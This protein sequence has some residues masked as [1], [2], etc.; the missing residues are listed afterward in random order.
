MP[1]SWIYDAFISYSHRDMNWGRWLQR[2]LET[3]KIPKD[4]VSEEQ[5]AKNFRV[6]RDQTDL[7]GVELQTA[8]RK[9]LETS[10]FLIV[11][12]SPNSAASSW[13]NDEVVAFHEMGRMDHV[14]PFI[15]EGEPESEDPSLECY[16]PGLRS[17][18]GRHMLGANIQE[19]GKE[20]AF[21]KLVSIMLDVRFN[22]LVDRE[23]QRR[24]RMTLTIGSISAV[25][26]AIV[27][28]LLI[29]NAMISKR[30]HELSYDAYNSALSAAFQYGSE[31]EDEL[32][33]VDI[34]PLIASSEE[35]NT[36]AI[37][38]L[39]SCYRNGWGTAVDEDAAFSWCKKGAE[40]GDPECMIA[41]GHCY[42]YGNGTQVNGEEALN[43]YLKAAETDDPGGMV[44]AGV[45]YEDGVGTEADPEQAFYWYKKAADTGYTG[46]VEQLAR[47]YL[48]GI[49]CEQ[50]PEEAFK[51]DMQLAELGNADAM[52]NAGLMYQYGFGTEEDPEK[53]YYWYRKGAEAGDAL[54][55]YRVAQ[56]T[57]TNYGTKNAAAEWYKRAVE[58]AEESGDTDVSEAAKEEIE[59]L[60]AAQ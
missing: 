41:L 40:L 30:N 33:D 35:G 47:C 39:V 56:C 42:R 1:G 20:K 60:N 7:A 50:N 21:L 49:G 55:A 53:A 32:A 37:M 2:R 16:P 4:M 43:W 54:S 36:D 58:L 25:T 46:G 31:L 38:L 28:G 57:E 24:R 13:V 27:I 22:R 52:Y 29:H 12:C 17:S 48:K 26:A 45:A 18:D 10:R 9:E 34:N 15:V 14:I 44:M 51:L 59:R 11:I 23:K 5:T 19:I 3:F 8:L 6:F